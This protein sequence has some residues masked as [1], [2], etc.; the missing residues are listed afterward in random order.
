[1]NVI[2]NKYHKELA[3][4]N[5]MLSKHNAGLKIEQLTL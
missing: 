1:M 5:S 3:Q 2:L 4:K